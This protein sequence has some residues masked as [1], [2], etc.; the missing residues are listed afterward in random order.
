ML[1]VIPIIFTDENNGGF[2]PPS[3]RAA[4]SVFLVH[5]RLSHAALHAE[6]ELEVVEA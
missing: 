4:G 1:T 5:H 3:L 6:K 2:I